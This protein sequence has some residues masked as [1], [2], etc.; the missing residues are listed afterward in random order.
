[1]L[2]MNHVSN[3]YLHNECMYYL[4][5]VIYE[6]YQIIP[7]DSFLVR[8]D[9]SV[10]YSGYQ[11]TGIPLTATNS[12]IISTT[13]SYRPSRTS[14]TRLRCFYILFDHFI[15]TSSMIE[16]LQKRPTR[17]NRRVVVSSSMTTSVVTSNGCESF[18]VS[19][20]SLI[21]QSHKSYPF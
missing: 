1:M 5:R 12:L 19:F 15:S 10:S 20:P 6:Q 8:F 2:S 11:N 18:A 9:G 16:S 21:T 4:Q 17:L 13:C 3:S 7:Q 14:S